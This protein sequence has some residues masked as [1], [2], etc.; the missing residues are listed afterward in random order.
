M[1]TF[2]STQKADLTNAQEPEFFPVFKEN[3]EKIGA[4]VYHVG[5]VT[6]GTAV[7][8][9]ILRE[10]QAERV[11]AALSKIVELMELDKL[12]SV[13]V[14][15]NP[16]EQELKRAEVGICGVPL[17]IAETGSLCQLDATLMERRVSSLPEVN[18]A[19]VSSS[20]IMPTFEDA[21]EKIYADC[22]AIPGF[23]SFV[24]GPSRTSD[25]ERVLTIGVHGP[26]RLIVIFID[27][28]K[29]GN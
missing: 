24:T 18:I 13:K 5:S 19:L 16:G 14:N 15:L 3:A 1:N 17:A 25:I 29:G 26:R 6:D 27:D 28:L 21:M 7:I 12:E 10:L 23:I 4:E 20:A 2:S 8:E 9:N 11:V 22:P